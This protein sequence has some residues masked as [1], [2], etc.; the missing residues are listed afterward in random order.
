MATLNLVLDKRRARKDGTFPLV[1]RLRIGR[2]FCD[3]GTA[4]KLKIGEFDERSLS[5]KDDVE[6]NQ[7][8]SELSLMYLKRLRTF[9]SQN[10][11][12]SDIYKVKEYLLN[13]EPENVTIK[14]FWENEIEVLKKSGR[15]GGARTY[16]MTLSVIN[17]LTNLKRPFQSFDY[18]DLINLEQK[19]Y[20]RGIKVNSLSV[21]LR[22]FRTICNKAI[23]HEL[24]SHEWYPFRKYTFRKEKTTPR[25][26][27]LKEMK[28]YFGL[29]L[30]VTS[31]QYESWLIG[32]LLFMLRG[33]NIKDLLLLSSENIKQGRVIYRRAKTGKLYSIQ[34][35]PEIEQLFHQFS[36]NKTLL[37]VLGDN[38][39]KDKE[40]LVKVILQKTKNINSHLKQVGK[41][42]D[43]HESITTYVFR[44]SYSNI[45]K[46]L[47]Y[48]KDM[49]A[50]AL[51][52][53]YGNSVTG[54]YLEQFDME[55][56]DEMNSE[57]I[58][59]LREG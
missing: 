27:S 13:R 23:K 45:A 15:H 9:L 21:Y 29:N 51:G 46:Q 53:E 39:L 10:P 4:Y 37:G 28:S 3:I 2:K 36:P 52:H 40:R 8:L 41:L 38:D 18:N 54:I 5:I 56:I 24:V 1:F 31:L 33:I 12:C 16:S 11:S 22:T 17:Q 25:V 30:K 42:I 7:N 26:L 55:L 6:A 50:E 49:I 20:S 32:Q 47:G 34:L 19:L 44:Y 43:A 59:S 35:L 48:S 57:I 14:S 58:N